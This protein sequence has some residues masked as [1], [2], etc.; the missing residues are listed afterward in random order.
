MARVISFNEYSWKTEDA[1]QVIKCI[2]SKDKET[3]WDIVHGMNDD[4]E[5]CLVVEFDIDDNI[6]E[7]FELTFK[8][9]FIILSTILTDDSEEKDVVLDTLTNILEQAILEK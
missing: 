7:I 5:F 6:E 2:E 1:D 9:A 8:E 4:D 3:C